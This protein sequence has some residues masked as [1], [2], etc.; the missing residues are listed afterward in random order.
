MS[1]F[2]QGL[3]DSW[4]RQYHLGP[5]PVCLFEVDSSCGWFSSLPG[6]SRSQLHT[7]KL[8]WEQGLLRTKHKNLRQANLTTPEPIIGDKILEPRVGWNLRLRLK[9]GWF[10]KENQS[11]GSRQQEE[12]MPGSKEQGSLLGCVFP[13]ASSLP[14]VSLVMK[15]LVFYFGNQYS[16]GPQPP[17]RGSVL[18][19]DQLG[20]GPHNRRWMEGKQASK[21]SPVFT[22]ALHPS[23]YCLCQINN[24]IRFS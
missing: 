21:A 19:R 22:A 18:V 11:Y 1:S 20:T 8:S 14:P 9:E 2:V 17:G 15:S 10:P 16:R 3:F 4:V 13:W 12:W 23:H 5:P 7:P 6:H 24:S